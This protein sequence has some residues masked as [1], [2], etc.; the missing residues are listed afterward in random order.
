MSKNEKAEIAKGQLIGALIGLARA[1]TEGQAFLICSK[2]FWNIF[3]MLLTWSR[4][5]V[6]ALYRTVKLIAVC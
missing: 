1:T 5:Q 4:L 6:I 3:K 2:F